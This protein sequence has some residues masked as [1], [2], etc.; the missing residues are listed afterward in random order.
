MPL[1]ADMTFEDDDIDDQQTE[2]SQADSSKG[3]V[4]R[5]SSRAKKTKAIFDPSDNNGPVHKRKKEALEAER[6]GKSAPP[7][8]HSK[9]AVSETILLKSPVSS[10]QKQPPTTS[11][12]IKKPKT[13]VKT[14]QLQRTVSMPNINKK[15]PPTK[16]A[17]EALKPVASVKSDEVS[18]TPIVPVVKEPSKRIQ[19]RK[20]SVRPVDSEYVFPEVKKIR[21]I[22]ASTAGGRSDDYEKAST[23]ELKITQVPDVRKWS[24]Q[25]VF[26]YF[27]NIGFSTNESSI[28]REEEIDGEALMIMKRSDM[29]STKFQKLKLG[30]ALKV[31]MAAKH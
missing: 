6:V 31:I 1:S 8:A 10:P 16:K 3:S 30:P 25:R 18:I 24:H 15:R 28:F 7:K 27:T 17:T 2:S 19:A 12:P 23:I 14:L 21:R 20:H 9:P 4:S 22:S 11:T 5:V 26:E 13:P 29:I